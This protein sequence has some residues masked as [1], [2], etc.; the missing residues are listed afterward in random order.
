MSTKEALLDGLRD[1]EQRER[2]GTGVA[3]LRQIKDEIKAL[4]SKGYTQKQVWSSLKEQGLQLTF[5][6]F[7]TFLYRMQEE[8]DRSQKVSNSLERCPRCGCEVVGGGSTVDKQTGV[9]SATGLG[10]AVQPVEQ[11]ANVN[12]RSESMGSVFARRLG[13]GSLSRGLR[14]RRSD[15]GKA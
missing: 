4:L 12:E 10:T 5:S 11:S 13:D 8:V 15:S 3:Q 9:V 6:G 14:N 7:K 1:L 2:P